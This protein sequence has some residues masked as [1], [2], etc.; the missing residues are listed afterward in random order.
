MLRNSVSRMRRDFVWHLS[1]QPAAHPSQTPPFARSRLARCA[2]N[3]LARFGPLRPLVLGRLPMGRLLS[4]PPPS[5]LAGCARHALLDPLRPHA[6]PAAP[7]Q[8]YRITRRSRRKWSVTLTGDSTRPSPPESRALPLAYASELATE[9][10]LA[11]AS[12]LASELTTTFFIFASLSASV[13]E[14]A[15]VILAVPSTCAD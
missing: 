10:T 1:A 11:Y 12:E 6:W 8:D 5:H 14:S 7:P 4:P 13:M 9:L 3:A 15:S 2:C